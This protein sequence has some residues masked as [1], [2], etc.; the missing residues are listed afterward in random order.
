[1]EIL[2]KDKPVTTVRLSNHL[3]VY[4]NFLPLMFTGQTLNMI[5]KRRAL[6]EDSSLQ[7]GKAFYVKANV[8]LGKEGLGLTVGIF[9][10]T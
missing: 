1:M 4:K 9:R 7:S 3:V 5:I 8:L 6:G 2:I 10:C